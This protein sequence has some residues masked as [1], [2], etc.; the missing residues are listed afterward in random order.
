M[1]FFRNKPE[2]PPLHGRRQGVHL[3]PGYTV[4][5]GCHLVQV[6]AEQNMSS[7]LEMCFI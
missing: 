3:I 7:C 2:N 6:I 5:L 4:Q 1:L